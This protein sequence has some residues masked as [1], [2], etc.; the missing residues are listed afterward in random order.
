[1]KNFTDEDLIQIYDLQEKYA[2]KV[3]DFVRHGEESDVLKFLQIIPEMNCSENWDKEP[4]IYRKKEFADEMSWEKIPQGRFVYK[5]LFSKWKGAD[6]LREIFDEKYLWEF[7]EAQPTDVALF[8]NNKEVALEKFSAE[9]YEKLR[10]A[11]PEKLKEKI[12]NLLVEY[13]SET[14]E[15]ASKVYVYGY[16]DTILNS[17]LRSYR[18]E[19][20][21][22]FEKL[23]WIINQENADTIVAAYDLQACL[24]IYQSN[25]EGRFLT[26]VVRSFASS[27][28]VFEIV[29]GEKSAELLSNAEE[30]IIKLASR[31]NFVDTEEKLPILEN[32]KICLFGSVEQKLKIPYKEDPFCVSNKDFEKILGAL[33]EKYEREGFSKK[34]YPS[35][36]EHNEYSHQTFKVVGR[37]K[38]E[39]ELQPQWNIVFDDGKIVTANA[40]EIISSAIN[41]RFYGEQVEN[42]GK[43]PLEKVLVNDSGKMNL[44][45]GEEKIS[46]IIQQLQKNGESTEKI[47][48]FLE[49]ERKNLSKA[50]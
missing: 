40:D 12:K 48:N 30:K 41:E 37:V 34:Y 23:Q 6:S 47:K 36:E 14:M 43:R 10:D 19:H 22:E 42:L 38:T 5:D 4:K 31:Y 7:A 9:K 35:S 16:T 3:V 50:R 32:H 46:A 27:K 21:P 26:D 45:E 18:N 17:R 24:K 28:E 25:S 13:P 20:M 33:A 1:M 15:T 29:Y 39:D 11:L 49:M 44:S 8:A 2:E